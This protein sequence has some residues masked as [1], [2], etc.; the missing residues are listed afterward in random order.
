MSEVKRTSSSSR[1]QGA[2]AKAT[3]AQIIANRLSAGS[4][5]EVNLLLGSTSRRQTTPLRKVFVRSDDPASPP[6]MSRIVSTQGR[7][8]AVT[9]KVYLGLLRRSS[10]DP[11]DTQLSSRRWARLLDLNDPAM[12]GARRVSDAISRLAD[13]NLVS[14][15]KVRGG[16]SKVTLLREDGT[17]EPYQPPGA[18]YK[19]KP[20]ERYFQL[21]DDLWNGYIQALSGPALAMLLV[22]SAEPASSGDGTWWS[23]ERFPEW[24]GL[25]AS[26]RA[27]GTSELQE[28][29]LLRVD[30]RMVDRPR[31]GTNDDWD[32]VRNV[33]RLLNP[34]ATPPRKKGDLTRSRLKALDLK[35][36]GQ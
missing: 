15:E 19:N 33:Y 10:K 6:P 2:I 18:R 35:A 16:P 24:Y 9:L 30:K 4:R 31:G 11:Y 28:V 29:K 23:V 1:R 3:R 22:L 13:L 25:S 20:V 36:A 27:K 12:L 8:G 14:V 17:G 34:A 5:E 32:R 26:M 21:P 7:G